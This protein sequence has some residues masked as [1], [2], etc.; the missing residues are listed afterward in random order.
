MPSW[1]KLVVSGSDA[2]VPSVSTAADFT[3]NAGSNI[4]LDAD[5]AVIKL[6]DDGTEFGRLSRVSSDLVIK[7][8][9]NNNDIIFKG[10]DNSS[11]I[12]ALTLDMS[13]AGNAI[14]TGNVTPS[15]NNAKN[16]GGASNVWANIYGYDIHATRH[17]SGSSI[18]TGSFGRVQASAIGGNSPLIIDADNLKL[19][20]TGALSGS[21]TSTGSFGTVFIPNQE[22]L[23]FGSIS[24]RIRGDNSNNNLTFHTNNT[25]RVRIDDTG[26]GIGGDPDVNF[27]IKLADTANARIEDTS[28]DGIAKLDFKNDQRQ[29]T[30]GVYGDDSDKFKIDHGGG[31]VL[32]IDVGQNVGIGTTSPARKLD[33]TGDI[34]ASTNIVAGTA[35]YSNELITRTGNTLTF[36]TSGGTAISTFM[37]TGN[38]G[39]GT[40]SPASKLHVYQDNSTTDTTN[41]LL[42]EN[43]GTGDAVAQFLLTGTKRYMMGIDNSDSDKFVINTGAGDLSSGN[44]ITFDSDM[45]MTT[46]GDVSGSSTSTGSF[47]KLIGDGSGL[48]GVTAEWDG[49]HTGNASITGNLAIG[50][51]SASEL[52]HVKKATGD[53]NLVVESVA[54]GT[55]PTLHIKSPADRAGVI[56]FSEGGALK[57]SI[58]H[59]TDDSLNFYLNSGNDATLQ[60]N[61]DKSIRM[62][63]NVG[64][65]MAPT[66]NFNLR[67]TGNVEFRIQST[68]DDARLQ[69]S[70][71]NDEGQDSILE[72]L[73]NTSTR[74]SILY[75][76]NTSAASQKMDFKV[77]DNAVTAIS[78]LGDGKVGIGATS[79][80]YKL[81]VEEGSGNEIARF[82]G[83]NSGNIVFRNS[84]SNEFVMYTGPSDAL[85]FGTGGNNERMRIDASGNVGIGTSSPAHELH[86][87]GNEPTFRHY[88]TAQSKY[89][90]INVGTGGGVSKYKISS[91]TASNTLVVGN[92]ARVGINQINASYN[93][94]ISANSGDVE[95]R[96]YR[97]AN[98]KSSLRFQNSIQ[99]WEIGNS[100][101]VNNEFSIKD[102]TDTRTPFHIDTAGLVGIGTTDPAEE[103]HISSSGASM[104]ID[105]IGSNSSIILGNNQDVWELYNHHGAGG[106]LKLYNGGDLV[107]FLA[108][109]NVGIGI[110]SPSAKLH[111][112]G[113]AIVTGKITAQEF[114]TEFVSAS[115]MYDSGSTKFGDTSNDIHSMS[116]SLRVTGSGYHYFSDGRLGIGTTSPDMALDVA[117][118]IGMDGFLYHNGDGDTYLRFENN[119]ASLYG[120]NSGIVV[121]SG[122]VGI[123][124]ESPVAQGLTIA[125]AGDVNLTLLAD[126]DANATNNWPMVDFR[127]DNVSGNPEARIYY[128]QDITSLVLATNNNNAV[129]VNS[130]G[131]VG[132][133]TTSPDSPLHVHKASAGSVTANAN[134]VLTLEDDGTTVLQ[135]LSPSDQQQQIRFGDTS[136]D[137]AGILSYNHSTN[138]MQ[139]AT[140][141]PIKMTLDG[142]GQ[143]GIGETSPAEKLDVAGSIRINN[144]GYI[145]TGAT[146]YEVKIGDNS[147]TTQY[148]WF[149]IKG[150]LDGTTGLRV[151]PRDEA[152]SIS[153]YA[154][155]SYNGASDYTMIGNASDKDAI[156]IKTSGN[157]GIGTTNPGAPF[158]VSSSAAGVTYLDSGHS[159]G[160][161]VRFRKGGTD[162]F[163]IG[164]SGGIGGGS[165]YY[166]H[167]AISGLG[168]RFFTAATQALV[169]DTSQNAEFAGNVSGSATSTGSFGLLKGDGS[170]LTNISATATAAGNQYN[171]QFN[172]SGTA[173]GGSDNFV[174]NSSNN[175]VGIGTSSPSYKLHIQGSDADMMLEDGSGASLLSI[176][177]AGNGYINAGISL[178]STAGTHD[179]GMGIF[180]HD[181]GAD[182]EWYAGVPYATGGSYMIGYRTS[183]AAHG[184]DTAQTTYA[185]MTIKNSGD[186]GIGTTSP[187]SP[188]HIHNG[189]TG[190]GNL[191]ISDSTGYNANLVVSSSATNADAVLTLG[192]NGAS[193]RDSYVMFRSNHAL[194]Y[195]LQNDT[196]TNLF[197]IGSATGTAILTANQSGNFGIGANIS[198]PA[199]KL[200][201]R[202]TVTGSMFHANMST[203]AGSPEY[204]FGGDPDTGMYSAGAN[205][206]GFSTGGTVRLN[207]TSAYFTSQVTGGVRLGI[208]N[209]SA[210]APTYTFNDDPDTGI[211]RGSA[212]NISFTT[213]GTRRFEIDSTGN[214][215]IKANDKHLYGVTSGLAT[216][217]LI[218]VRGDNYVEIGHSGYGVVTGTGSWSLD[219]AD[220]M[221]VLA[222]AY[223]GEYLYHYGDTDTYMHF[224]N[225]RLILFAG[226]DNIL[227]YEED[228]SSTLKL[229]GGGEADVTIG[230]STTFFVG[231]S[232]GSYDHNVGIGTATPGSKLDIVGGNWNTSLTIKGGGANS[233]IKFLDSD[234][235][236]DGYIYASGGQIGFMDPGG[237]FG[238][239]IKDDTY[240]DFAIGAGASRMRIKSNGD[241][242]IGTTD[243]EHKLHVVGD[244]RATGDVI[245]NRLVI[246]SSVSHITSSFS[247][248][249][250]IFGDSSADTHQF[251]GSLKVLGSSYNHLELESASGNVGIVFDVETSATNYYDWRIDAQ[252]LVA[253]GLCIGRSTG[254]GNQTF[255]AS[256][257]VMTL[258]SDGNVGIG[259]TSPDD[260][261]VVYG[262][263]KQIRMGADDSNHVVIGRN[264]STG[265]F[266]MARTCTNAAEE[267]FFRAAEHE[268]GALTFFTSEVA[269]F[270]I[271]S[272]SRISLSNNDSGASGRSYNTIFGYLAGDD[273]ANTG[274][275]NSFF[276]DNT[277]HQVTTG[278]YN[279]A[280]GLN[281]LDGAT[282]PDR[283]TAIGSAAL[284]GNVTAAAQG[285]VGVGYAALNGLT[286]AQASTAVGY[287]AGYAITVGDHN[288]ILGHSALRYEVGGQNSV[289]IG[290][291]ALY[292]QDGGDSDT[293]MD[294]I[295]IG[296]NV[297][298]H[299]VTGTKNTYVGTFAGQGA[300]SYSN[301]NNVGLGYSTLYSIRTGTENV[302][303]GKNS[304][305]TVTTGGQNVAV[306]TET[307]QLNTATGNT[308]VGHASFAANS[309]GNQN[310]GL[311]YASGFANTTG[312]YN[313]AVGY[314]ALATNVDGDSNTAIGRRALYTFEANSDG[315]GENTAVGALSAYALT[316]GTGNTAVGKQALA[317]STTGLNNT[318]I[319][320]VA[321]GGGTTTGNNN[322]AVGY[323]A[324]YDLTSGTGNVIVGKDSGANVTTGIGNVI[325]GDSA[326]T[327][328]VSGHNNVIIGREAGQNVTTTIQKNVIVGYGAGNGVLTTAAD[329]LVAVG[330]AAGDAVTSAARITAVGYGA[331]GAEDA[332]SYQ[333][334]VG[335]EALGQ[336]NNDNG[337]NTALGQRAGYTL[338]SGYSCTLI[339]SGA[340]S[341]DAGGQNRI[342][343]GQGVS[344]GANN[345]AVIG[346]SSVTALYAAQDAG[347]TIYAAGLVEGSSMT[348]KENIGEIESP[349]DKL[350]KLR[351]VEF[352]YKSTKERSIGMIAEEVNEVFPELVNKNEDGEVT[353]MSY[354][355][356][357]A[358]LLEAVKELSQEVKDSREEIRELK[359]LNNYSKPGD[360]N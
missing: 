110:T 46:V 156:V 266:E 209:G 70:S 50:H 201:V 111:V 322:V 212:D 107:T 358:V 132:I 248:G 79:V 29:G 31:A 307:L 48:T 138:A 99:H 94:D 108:S 303:I 315:D 120:G 344:V 267:I 130:S 1:K 103:L 253:N 32:T 169:L 302:A 246:S 10:V 226:G 49:S 255:D 154:H 247:S 55:T 360:K 165:G 137:G 53:V 192:S 74:G 131:N 44:R 3:I 231:G 158:H 197:K 171:V 54:A 168:I 166:D 88:D 261:L 203:D 297:G 343:I 170:A 331:L 228:A 65:G 71:D 7:S 181:A 52:L 134:S 13:E 176:K 256:G 2:S 333:T 23:Q 265:H 34:G 258:K 345:I 28:S 219:G 105:G 149:S 237:D 47:G 275:Y 118:D 97:N 22:N 16:L 273:L 136:D 185:L 217:Q 96:L 180:M 269:R 263:D 124:T 260:K 20:T 177:G 294:N 357:T 133:G 215:V 9:G 77:G 359:K 349:L 301:S 355:R 18:S 271:D 33:V 14:F 295:G 145:D 11:T 135:F 179:R 270:V 164:G 354:S 101:S 350:T 119:K 86:L 337:H 284:R 225:D 235:N 146:P 19:D 298:Y 82:Q 39:I 220:N 326:G 321:M 351:G 227:D 72:F 318:A 238:I 289:A 51:S 257:T 121:N 214:L 325:L 222:N 62:Y 91:E 98:V 286:S 208:A 155:F 100:V 329:G 153:T 167:Y 122:N 239:S 152:A 272:N 207:L 61:S 340:D 162:Q 316:T 334:A 81:D 356:M 38:V 141:G 35:L 218:G 342:G 290:S 310:V 262:G 41:G 282:A 90:D 308:A 244:I 254:L 336:V 249:S 232:Q 216:I 21:S 112:D 281:A 312:L 283:V 320:R 5:G 287:E 202:G 151:Y 251:T 142:S 104:R 89:F 160:P 4:N 200:D 259:D 230:D 114:H 80:G 300:S 8:S 64:I 328:L 78:I 182:T 186:V 183:I 299:N 109:G 140:A 241:V 341:S 264:S 221:S 143:L 198:T 352:D 67:S 125:N 240:I 317:A 210:G 327:S 242:G 175:R 75:D 306:G 291:S 173:V 57:T 147:T 189:H 12:T 106:P 172:S 40:T 63:G 15:G 196:D 95:A 233:G 332:G 68:D 161:H 36:K 305:L 276:G 83:A 324:G 92:N 292:T 59:G 346:N 279:A 338:T 184:N 30:I 84:T 43:D 193:N 223:F 313:T 250:T 123:G 6:K 102:V 319:G 245:A 148:G 157:V 285:A 115:I 56:K 293:A 304:L 188:L 45:N 311:G 323:F 236:V 348:L 330:S 243:P 314:Q 66:H 42:V 195:Y 205:V 309:S 229:A 129:V 24:T 234:N 194:R 85:I 93:L 280:F 58:F 76:H 204:S 296:R 113:D 191:Y 17:I 25:E 73:S 353:A 174:F 347:A 117:G 190:Q 252:G 277:G 127:V 159:N 139:F 187:L 335:Y 274:L 26:M 144:G 87:E 278:D 213:G 128:K 163:Y 211:Y 339:G 27:H 69:I 178:Q 126:S 288:T 268:A 37:N 116:G 199:G 224:L 150:A 60:L 206:L